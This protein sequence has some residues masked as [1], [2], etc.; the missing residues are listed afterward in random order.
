MKTSVY[1][2][3]ALE[4][5]LNRAV[6]VVKEAPATVLRIALRAGL[7]IVTAQFQPQ[8]N[9]QTP[10]KTFDFMPITAYGS[11]VTTK[12]L[13]KDGTP[14]ETF[15]TAWRADKEA[16]KAEGFFLGK[17]NGKWTVKPGVRQTDYKVQYNGVDV[18][19]GQSWEKQGVL[20]GSRSAADARVAEL[21]KPLHVAT[22]PGFRNSKGK[23]YSAEVARSAQAL[24]AQLK[25]SCSERLREAAVRETRPSRYEADKLQVVEV[26][27]YRRPRFGTAEEQAAFETTMLARHD[28]RRSYDDLTSKEKSQYF[29]AWKDA[30]DLIDEDSGDDSGFR[31]E[32]QRIDKEFGL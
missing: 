19:P 17:E 20:C 22:F 23:P 21:L 12:Y 26:V 30:H 3:K 27:S 7:P 29:E 24:E 11:D 5:E 25:T 1:L 16:V 4:A 6:E 14:T 9:Y 15:W 32:M 10:A 18:N 13:N 28:L 2:D 31:R 8:P